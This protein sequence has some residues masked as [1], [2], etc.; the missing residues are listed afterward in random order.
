MKAL[1][2]QA[3]ALIEIDFHFFSFE[4]QYFKLRVRHRN[5]IEL[6]KD[7]C[8]NIPLGIDNSP[9]YSAVEMVSSMMR[10]P[11]GAGRA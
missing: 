11:C 1:Q 10:G 5:V 9:V 7:F 8:Q 4:A 2:K 6:K 3:M